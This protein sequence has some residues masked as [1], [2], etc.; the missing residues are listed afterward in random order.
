VRL[1]LSFVLLCAAGCGPEAMPP[2]AEARCDGPNGGFAACEGTGVAL[3]EVRWDVT[4]DRH[5][6][7]APAALD[8][9]QDGLP[10][11][12]VTS[13]VAPARLYRNRGRFRFEDATAGV[14]V[15]LGRLSAAAV[16]D[17]DRD[18]HEDLVVA[19]GL[20]GLLDSV[21]RE[22]P[23]VVP[24]SVR[25]LRGLGSCRFEE[26]TAPWGF[27]EF[28]PEAPAFV[29]N[30]TLFDLNRDGWTDVLVG[31]QFSGEA[32]PRL[33]L[34]DARGRWVENGLGLLGDARGELWAALFA[35]ATGDEDADLWLLFDGANGPAARVLTG[36]GRAPLRETV[37]EPDLF[38]AAAS[39]HSLMGAALGDLDHD[40]D[41]DVYL[42][43]VGA[44]HLLLAEPGGRW[45]SAA[46]AAGV[47][48]QSPPKGGRTVGF[49]SAFLD[50][51]NDG[52]LDLVLTSS[53]D[54]DN[55]A[56]P[57]AF[58]FR[59]RGDGTFEDRSAL[60]GQTMPHAQ[61]ALAVLDLDRDGRLDLWLGG[62]GEPPRILANRVPAGDFITFRLRGTRGDPEGVGARVTVTVGARTLVQSL[63]PTGRPF[64]YDPRRL[65][66]GLGRA[67]RVDSVEVRWP[68]GTVQRL[69]PLASGREHTLTEPQR[70]P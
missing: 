29:G 20:E 62:S 58:L 10:D 45:R 26:R 16:G 1:A 15:T 59:N 41:L 43:D 38:G 63:N 42:T 12:L 40:G 32:R 27:G 51:D 55:R 49:S 17:L 54:R 34:S 67:N 22:R 7:N 44:Q 52:A 21:R 8:C 33:Y 61:E 39:T 57:F 30:L 69:G 50:Y 6:N 25:V 23:A 31:M 64:G 68:G 53:V 4:R 35:D 36:D 13:W 47:A 11:V 28:T 3:A 9:D 5:P 19:S 37:P 56:P 48:A 14:G 70:G 24:L 66:F 18:G 46:H 2:P 60:L 65:H